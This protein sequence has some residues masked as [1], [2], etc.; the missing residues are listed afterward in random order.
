MSDKLRAYFILHFCVFIWGFTAVLGGLIS[1]KTVP[2]VWW[3]VAIA[4]TALWFLMPKAQLRGL[5]RQTAIR[6]F[7]IGL[8]VGV[9]WLCFYGAIK[10]ANA[11]VAVVTMATTSFFAAFTEPLILRTR[12]RWYELALGILVLPGMALV[13][14][15]IDYQMR[16]GFAVGILSGFLAAV[17]SVFNKKILESDAPPALAMSF[18]EMSAIVVL[19]SVA[20]P[21]VLHFFP[22]ENFWPQGSGDW[23]WLLVLA[24]VC[25]V[26]P[27]FLSLKAMRHVSAYAVNLTLNLEPVYGVALAGLI[28]HEHKDL[29]PKFYWGVFIILAAVFSHPFLKRRFEPTSG[30]GAKP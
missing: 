24:L 8:L 29:E 20:M 11:S 23:V 2:L 6:L 10:L 12:F 21:F 14:E 16:T 22:N 5:S 27:F 9:H 7:G 15:S 18:I 28:L 4:A 13:V 30:G 1:L 26:L 19:T 3:R 17:F 25:T